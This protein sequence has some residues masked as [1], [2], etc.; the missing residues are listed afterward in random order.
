MAEIDKAASLVKNAFLDLTSIIRFED[1][2]LI[3]DICCVVVGN[4]SYSARTASH[5]GGRGAVELCK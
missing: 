3:R 4:R 1:G 5:Q 2:R